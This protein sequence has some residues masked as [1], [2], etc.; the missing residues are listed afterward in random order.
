MTYEEQAT[1]HQQE[2]L[3]IPCLS[4]SR[5]HCPSS[6]SDSRVPS[7]SSPHHSHSVAGTSTPYALVTPSVS[8]NP[9]HAASSLTPSLLLRRPSQLA[10]EFRLGLRLLGEELLIVEL[11][12]RGTSDWLWRLRIGG[13]GTV[14]QGLGTIGRLVMSR[15]CWRS[16]LEVVVALSY[17]WTPHSER[18][19][20]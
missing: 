18:Q 2:H 17:Y 8:P 1:Q 4:H 7:P 5:L 9:S 20:P 16:M 15:H 6:K 13:G 3:M 19:Q 12:V 11:F 14:H 10:T